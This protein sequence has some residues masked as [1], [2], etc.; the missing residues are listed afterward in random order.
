MPIAQELS[1]ANALQGLIVVRL[2]HSVHHQQQRVTDRCLFR[3]SPLYFLL[4]FVSSR[5]LQLVALIVCLGPMPRLVLFGWT[6]QRQLSPPG[7][8][9]P[10]LFH[11]ASSRPPRRRQPMA[12]GGQR[13]SVNPTPSCIIGNHPP[14]CLSISLLG[15]RL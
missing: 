9:T 5:C 4:L 12:T 13:R 2:H 11:Q 1:E 14:N 7:R 3:N 8:C 6:Q 15:L 10:W